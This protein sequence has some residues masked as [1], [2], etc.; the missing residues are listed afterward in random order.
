MKITQVLTIGC[1][2]SNL[3]NLSN[4]FLFKE[5]LYKVHFYKVCKQNA[6]K[7]GGLHRFRLEL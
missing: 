4:L 5:S 6:D 1:N 3:S 2:L 7:N